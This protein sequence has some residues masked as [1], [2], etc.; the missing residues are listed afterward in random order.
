MNRV[1]WL[2]LALAL[3]LGTSAAEAQRRK[4][5]I[6]VLGGWQFGGK[7]NAFE[8]EYSI[9]DALAITGILDINLRPGGQLELMYDWQ[10]TQIDLRNAAGKRKLFDA[11]LH[12]FQI[13][14]LGYVDRGK[15]EPFGVATLG[16][17]YINPKD[18]QYSG[19]TR[20]SFTLGGGAKV[21]PTERIGLRFEGR[22]L[23]TVIDGAIGL[24]CGTGG[25]G[26]SLW[27]WGLVQGVVSAGLI[28]AL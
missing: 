4:A 21:F 9:K 10:G 27:G 22:L 17:T 25:C 7:L 2:V 26:G 18:S 24:G 14:G 28:L 13:G 11:D 5:E 15:V 1:T 20:F 8:G 3:C 12:Y 19:E 16:L 23:M 6:A